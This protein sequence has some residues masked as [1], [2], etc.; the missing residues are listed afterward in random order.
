MIGNNI[1]FKRMYPD[2]FVEITGRM[3]H[4]SFIASENTRKYYEEIIKKH[5]L[6]NPPKDTLIK[7]G[8]NVIKKEI[9]PIEKSFLQKLKNIFL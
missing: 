8:Q 2:D 3:P 9:K 7:E 4:E 5:P 6:N 1:S